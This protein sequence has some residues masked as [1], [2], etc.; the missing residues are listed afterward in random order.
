MRNIF[1]EFREEL[2]RR[3]VEREALQNQPRNGSD[4]AADGRPT[5]KGS[6]EDDTM[7]SDEPES[8]GSGRDDQERGPSPIFRRG[9]SGGGYR[10]YSGGPSGEIPQINISRG[11]FVLGGIALILFVLMSAF[12]MCVGLATDAMW[13]GSIGFSNVFWT[14]LGSQALFFA[15]GAAI[16]FLVLWINLWLAGRFIPKGQTRRFSLDDLLDRFNVDRYLSGG[17]FGGGPFTKPAPRTVKG[18]SVQVPE[19]GRPVFWSLLGISLLVAL[20]MGG[21]ALSG[22]NTIQLF[23]HETPFGQTDPTF[24]K[25]ISFFMFEL[26]FFRLV[27]SYAN[28]LV[29]VALALVGIRYLIAVISG[30]SMPTAARVHLGL[31]V[32]LWLWSAAVGYQ[33]DRYELVYSNTSTI[34]QGISYTDNNA[35]MLAFNVMTVLTAFVGC[36][37]LALAYTRWRT[38]LVLTLVFWAGAYLVLDV[39]YPQLVQRFSVEPN[40]QTQ[41]TPYIKNNIDMTRLAFNLTGWTSSTYQPGAT[42]TQSAVQAEASTIQ[43]V[44]LWDYQPLQQTLDQLQV[45]RNYYTF[46]DVDTDR[47]VFTDSATCAPAAP[48]CVRQVMMAGARLRSR[49]VRRLDDRGCQL[50]EP[51][52][53]LHPRRRTS[54]GPRQ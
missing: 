1:D 38:P 24:G 31:L 23:L 11:W 6:P 51:A 17:G 47:Y 49:Q 19:L 28:S 4:E 10:R 7:S 39:G 25:D 40:Q 20:A 5:T 30:A 54:D 41:E 33:L 12:A 50:G 52:H 27:Q 42:V 22:W 18:E 14:R 29:L 45:I 44:R 43:N 35:K 3:Q 48:P 46:T 26:P 34:F 21:L 36:F 15:A 13:F 2:R 53:Q 32:A 16:A 37:I 9:G 8:G